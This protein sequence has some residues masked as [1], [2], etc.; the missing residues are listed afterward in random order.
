MIHTEV[1]LVEAVE[2][3]DFKSQVRPSGERS[4][5]CHMQIDGVSPHEVQHLDPFMGTRRVPAIT[6]QRDTQTVRR[7]VHLGL[8]VP[9]PLDELP[10]ARPSVPSTILIIIEHQSPSAEET[11]PRRRVKRQQVDRASQRQRVL[12]GESR[13]TQD[14]AD[15]MQR[16]HLCIVL[17]SRDLVSYLRKNGSAPA[18]Q[19]TN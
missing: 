10:G 6:C 5:R 14:L 17:S 4:G 7:A 18:L 11:A 2:T 1:M 9:I 13:R 12:M 16:W 8:A 19:K 15:D 3:P